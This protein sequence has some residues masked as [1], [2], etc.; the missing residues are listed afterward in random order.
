MSEQLAAEEIVSL[1]PAG[2]IRALFGGTASVVVAAILVVLSAVG[3]YH[4]SMAPDQA[5]L[6]ATVNDLQMRLDEKTAALQTTTSALAELRTNLDG[7]QANIAAIN[8]RLATPQPSENDWIQGLKGDAAAANSNLMDVQKWSSDAF[9][10]VRK[11]GVQ[12][13]LQSPSRLNLAPQ[14]RFDLFV[15]PAE[16]AVQSRGPAKDDW[17]T[18]L[19]TF[20]H[21][22]LAAIF[23]VATV[24]LLVF[25][26][27][28]A[29][30]PD[31][32]RVKFAQ[33]MIKYILG[34]Y[35]G[36]GTGSGAAASA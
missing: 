28:Y 11:P 25:L 2:R 17:L 1:P 4:A 35:V 31:P 3:A 32:N 8:N 21:L 18:K 10:A 7:L 14:G 36:L 12:D 24:V 26:A 29:L 27:I 20:P 13:Y 16:A 22:L 15:T 23:L 33:S 30:S 6:V 19:L 9:S 34:F 5:R